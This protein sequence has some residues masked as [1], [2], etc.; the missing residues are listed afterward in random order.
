MY[1]YTRVLR[2]QLFKLICEI[3]LFFFFFKYLLHFK[4]RLDVSMG[5]VKI[6]M[7]GNT[8]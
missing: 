4:R 6:Q 5:K 3:K 8:E 7:K 2:R 1:K